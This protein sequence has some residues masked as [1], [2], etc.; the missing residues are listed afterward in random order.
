MEK[1]EDVDSAA[2]KED[3]EKETGDRNEGKEKEAEDVSKEK[4]KMAEM[5]KDTLADVKGEGTEGKMDLDDCKG[6]IDNTYC[7]KIHCLPVI[8]TVFLILAEEGKEEKNTSF[9]LAEEKKGVLISDV[10]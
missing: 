10:L 1:K 9:S 2:G 8:L 4:D 5:E 7:K 6:E 3:K